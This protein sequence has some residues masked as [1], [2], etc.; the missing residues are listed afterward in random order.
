MENKNKLEKLNE[1]KELLDM[2]PIDIDIMFTIIDD[3]KVLNEI[4]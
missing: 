3:S 2:D 4:W 1:A